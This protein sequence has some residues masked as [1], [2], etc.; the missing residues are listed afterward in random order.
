MFIIFKLSDTTLNI[1]KFTII[2]SAIVSAIGFFFFGFGFILGTALVMLVNLFRLVL[3]ERATKNILNMNNQAAVNYARLQ[4]FLRFILGG[5]AV[6]LAAMYHPTIH[7]A[8]VGAGVIAMHIATY[9]T[10]YSRLKQK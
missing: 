7:L 5:A 9:I 8:G 10:S 6:F 2:I 1:I 3:I 4:Y